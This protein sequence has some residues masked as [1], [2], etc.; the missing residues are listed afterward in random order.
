MDDFKTPPAHTGFHAK[1]LF[2]KGGKLK[3][4]SVAYMEPD[5][6]GR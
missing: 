2:G 4:V 1:Q 5:G 3:D 6:G